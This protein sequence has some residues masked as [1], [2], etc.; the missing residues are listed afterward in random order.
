MID[1]DGRPVIDDIFSYKSVP[2]SLSFALFTWRRVAVIM[3]NSNAHL[4]SAATMASQPNV[5][6]PKSS[7][8]LNMKSN[9]MLVF[10]IFNFV[11][12]LVSVTLA[13][14]LLSILSNQGNH[15]I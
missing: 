13:V 14:M 10:S 12:C 7:T 2:G 8:Y 4:I 3:Y 11:L 5:F 15:C 1:R 9:A 6:Q